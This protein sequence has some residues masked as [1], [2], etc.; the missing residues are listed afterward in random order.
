MSMNGLI[1]AAA[2]G[3]IFLR[4]VELLFEVSA[5]SL[6]KAA[7]SEHEPTN[8]RQVVKEEHQ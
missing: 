4:D 7:R 5:S 3:T 8:S 1:M 2:C 6:F